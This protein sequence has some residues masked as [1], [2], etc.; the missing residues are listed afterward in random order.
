MAKRDDDEAEDDPNPSLV[1]I[2]SMGD[3]ALHVIYVML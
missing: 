3:V 2:N 1:V